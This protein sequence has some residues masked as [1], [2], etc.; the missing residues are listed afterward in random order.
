MCV[1]I[2]L[3]IAMYAGANI[4]VHTAVLNA[5][6]AIQSIRE[7]IYVSLLRPMKLFGILANKLDLV[8]R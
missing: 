6:E 4:V 7:D 1:S 2:L 3:L 8:K 5:H